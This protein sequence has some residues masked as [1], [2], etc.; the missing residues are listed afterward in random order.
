MENLS[1]S[2]IAQDVQELINIGKPGAVAPSG[3]ITN[4]ETPGF[5]EL[6]KSALDAVNQQQKTAAGMMTDIETGKSK[7]LLGAML[8]SQKASLSFQALV[9][10][11]NK[12]VAAYEEIMRMQV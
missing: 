1:T 10:I 7:D 12:A 11:R 8:A 5:G 9:Q 4:E 3:A 6:M 2:Q